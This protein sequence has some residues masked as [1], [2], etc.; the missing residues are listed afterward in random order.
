[1]IPHERIDAPFLRADHAPRAIRE[2]FPVGDYFMQRT[3]AAPQSGSLSIGHELFYHGLLRQIELLRAQHA[4]FY[5][6]PQKLREHLHRVSVLVGNV[7]AR[8][9]ERVMRE[10]VRRVGIG[11]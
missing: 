10:A 2:R 7:Y 6:L 4:L 11:K 8:H 5:C 3:V 9:F 1:M